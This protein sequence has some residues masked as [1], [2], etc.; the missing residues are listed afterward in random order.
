MPRYFFHAQCIPDDYGTELPDLD[1]ARDTAL[2][3]LC[4]ILPAMA[5]E[6]WEAG[7][8]N[9]TVSDHHGTT[10]V[11]FETRVTAASGASATLPRPNQDQS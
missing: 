11:A 5:P 6:F 1:S 8:F 7:T 4:Q 9:L 2:T 3:T 10:L